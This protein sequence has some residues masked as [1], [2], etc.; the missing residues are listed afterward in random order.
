MNLVALVMFAD[1]IGLREQVHDVGVRLDVDQLQRLITADLA[2]FQ[3]ALPH[4]GDTIPN[5]QPSAGFCH[6]HTH[7]AANLAKT[8]RLAKRV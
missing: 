1:A 7:A 6:S 4:L 3:D 8:K 5:R 2:T